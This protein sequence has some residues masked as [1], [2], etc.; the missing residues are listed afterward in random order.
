MNRK[1][2]KKKRSLIKRYNSLSK[3]YDRLYEEEQT[4]KINKVLERVKLS[5]SDTVLDI[6]CGTGLLLEQACGSVRFIL[7]V[8]MSRELLKISGRRA[9]RLHNK[10]SIAFVRADADHLPLKNGVFSKVF[11][12]TLLQNA[13]DFVLTISNMV[14]V[15]MEDSVIVITALKK[16]FSRERFEEILDEVHLDCIVVEDDSKV[17]DHIALCQSRIS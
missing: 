2:W 11:A 5:R 12:F 4:Q 1:E 14:V 16:T 17:R 9:R 13:T 7:G 6:G 15:S 8:D 3:I 10:C